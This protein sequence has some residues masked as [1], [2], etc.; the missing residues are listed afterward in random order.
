VTIVFRRTPWESGVPG[1]KTKTVVQGDKRLRLVQF[2]LDFVEQEWC[3]RGHAGFMLEGA[4]EV[5]IDGTIVGYQAGDGLL[6]PAGEATRHRHHATLRP[7]T[8]FLVE[9]LD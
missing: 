5:D 7:A 6:I 1:L 3:T 4:M 8:L 9:D 2:D